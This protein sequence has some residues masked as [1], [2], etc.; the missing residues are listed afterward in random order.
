MGMAPPAHNNPNVLR[1][2]CKN[3]SDPKEVKRYKVFRIS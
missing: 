3:S 1:K 2:T